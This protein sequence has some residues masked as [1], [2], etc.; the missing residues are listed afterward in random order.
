MNFE[1]LENL[2]KGWYRGKEGEPISKDILNIIKEAFI[3]Y[4]EDLPQPIFYP[5]VRGGVEIE[6]N[7]NNIETSIK[8][9]KDMNIGNIEGYDLIENE[10]TDLKF[11]GWDKVFEYLRDVYK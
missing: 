7:E 2:K 4:P 8:I 1:Y 3:E 9:D 6:W 11:K 10:F 5:L